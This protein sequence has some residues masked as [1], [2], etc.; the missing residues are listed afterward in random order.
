[1]HEVEEVGK[2]EE[3]YDE[4]TQVWGKEGKKILREGNRYGDENNRSCLKLLVSVPVAMLRCSVRK[5]T[6]GMGFHFRGWS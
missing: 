3:W 2:K 6:N 1:M 4:E 5:Q